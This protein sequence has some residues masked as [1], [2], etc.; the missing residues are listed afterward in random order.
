M[1]AALAGTEHIHIGHHRRNSG[2]VAQSRNVIADLLDGLMQLAHYLR[3]GLP[4]LT[5]L[6]DRRPQAVQKAP[7]AGDAGVAEIA[8]L[9]EWTEEHE[10][11]TK[12]V[13]SPLANVLVRHH[14]VAA[15]LRHLRTLAH[16]HSVRT[17]PLEGLLEVDVTQLLQNH[18]DEPRVQ[19]VQYGVLVPAD[20]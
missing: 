9:L 4:V 14:D 19:Q 3:I 2:V 18:G 12:R 1:R 16:D 6:E 20:V 13:R 11:G 5:S 7:D 17:E 15:A 10:V 8:A